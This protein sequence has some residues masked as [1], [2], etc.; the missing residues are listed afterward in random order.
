[1]TTINFPV[2]NSQRFLR[3][4]LAFLIVPVLTFIVVAALLFWR[5][6]QYATAH[7]DEQIFT[8][9][10]V[11]GIDVSH[12]TAEEAV[13][14]V[15]Q[16]APTIAERTIVLEDAQS[17]QSWT[18]DLSALGVTHDI[19]GAVA[20]AAEIGRNGNT[21][22]QLNDQFRVWYNGVGI[23]PSVV[24]DE[25]EIDRWLAEI[26]AQIDVPAIDAQIEIVG[27]DVIYTPPQIGRSLNRSATRAAMLEPFRNFESATLPLVIETVEPR[28]GDVS[29][30]AA[31]IQ[32]MIGSPVTLYF[33]QPLDGADLTGATLSTAQLV[34]WLRIE[35]QQQGDTIAPSVFLDEVAVR[36]WV[37][38][39]SADLTREPERA[40]FYFDDYTSELV[41]VEP[42]TAGRTLDVNATVAKL[43]AAVQT[44]DRSIPFVVQE[45]IPTI[46]A[47]STAVELGITEL[48]TSATTF[49]AGS[50]PERMAN[51][52]RSADNFYGI[53]IAPGE[54][55]SYNQYLGEISVEQGYETGLIIFGDRT[56][57]G[58][59]GG[60]CQVSTTL[61]QAV[62]WSGLEIGE[63]W[64]HGYRVSYYEDASAP[65]GLSNVGMDATIYSPIVDFTFINNT[66]YHLLIENYYNEA[67]ESLTFK[68]YST[69]L[70]RTVERDLAVWN[71][72][73]PR[74]T[75]YHYNPEWEGTDLNQIEWATGG[76]DVQITRNVY[77]ADGNL[78]DQDIISSSY[79]PWRD[80]FEYGDNTD[81]S[82]LPENLRD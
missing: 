18:R 59:G 49:F 30:A 76:A 12:L 44:D 74:P 81:R 82:L 7:S 13:A 62:F 66:P 8:G 39:F 19:A 78:R 24:V 79:I 68:F 64:P 26:A 45:V 43:L 6:Q 80:I 25:G 27:Q 29:E 4:L 14:N 31:Q 60:V 46:H 32:T 42:H 16:H 52:A 17:G 9:V 54:E 1:M 56:I 51:I 41:L 58:I 36:N 23:T 3:G 35:W 67:S 48:I 33:E 55:F 72:T 73:E 34:E 61:Y 71:E 22:T 77:N 11:W 20:Q 57:A 37:D 53:V 65:D 40:R 47:N 5:V 15:A 63:R 50:S 38:G 2:S 10:S 70:G 21:Q 75:E 28:I 69:S